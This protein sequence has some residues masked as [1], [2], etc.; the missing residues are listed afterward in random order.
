MAIPAFTL[1]D[2]AARRRNRVFRLVRAALSARRRN[3]GARRI[4]RSHHRKPA[5]PL[6]RERHPRRCRRHPPGRRG[7]DRARSAR[8]LCARQPRA[9]LRRRRHHRAD[10]Q[11]VGRRRGFCRGG[12]ISSGRRAELGSAPRHDTRRTF[13]SVGLSARSQRSHYHAG[14]DRDPHGAAKLRCHHRHA[15]HRRLFLGPSDLSIALSGG[16]TSIR[17]RKRSM[18]NSTA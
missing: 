18:P 17:C 1:A 8:R 15:G 7:A 4:F 13:R 11:Y 9:R 16:K 3:A 2:P 5:R 14:D 10:D 6:G 12:K